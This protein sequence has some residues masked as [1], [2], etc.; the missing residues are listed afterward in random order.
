MIGRRLAVV[1]V[2]LVVEIGLNAAPAL[3]DPARP[4][5]FD[6]EIVG[7]DPAAGGVSATV[8]GG[9]SFIELIVEAGHTVEVV[10]Y[11]GE[12]YLR[13]LAEGTVQRNRHS[14]STYLNDDRYGGVAIPASASKDAAPVWETVAEDGRYA[15]HDHRTHWMSRVDPP[16][17]RRGDVILEGFVPLVVDGS[18]TEL[19]VVSIWR[20]APFPGAVIFGV[21]IGVMLGVLGWTVRRGVAWL[22]MLLAAAALITGAADYLSVPAET[23]PPVLLWLLPATALVAAMA[24]GLGSRAAVWRQVLLWVAVL[25]L[26]LWAI[27]RWDWMWQPVLPSS[28]P[29]WLDRMVTAAVLSGGVALGVVLVATELLPR[30]H[31]YAEG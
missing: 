10:G 5:A 4:T 1:L 21:V 14:P 17:R 12:P 27:L 9:D 6:T 23:G 11:Q 7:F 26:V 16:G 31:R 30:G 28:L 8:V 24:S 3:A 2:L 20:A 15:W 18:E 29:F 22:T 25:D 13:F 19:Q